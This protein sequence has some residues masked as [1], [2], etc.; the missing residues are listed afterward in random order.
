MFS[1]HHPHYHRLYARGS[2]LLECM[3]VML[4]SII[5]LTISVPALG[6]VIKK[7]EAQQLAD[8]LATWLSTLYMKSFNQQR[9]I[10]VTLEDHKLIARDSRDTI[11]ARKALHLM[12]RL[13][14]SPKQL[15]FFASGV[16]SPAT[17]YLNHR[18]VLCT[19]TL[20]LRGRVSTQCKTS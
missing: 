9:D 4:I 6:A 20:S 10:T 2:I 15:R 1:A 17:L 14:L 18:G 5:A 7:S 11:I 8:G 19:V 3:L 16:Q 12:A 13:T